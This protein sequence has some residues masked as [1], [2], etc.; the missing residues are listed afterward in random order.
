MSY[1]VLARKYRPQRLDEVIGQEHVSKTL[2]NALAENR[3]AHAYLFAGPRGVGKTTMARI[4]AKA[5]NCKD[6]RDNEP[7]GKCSN[8]VEI[9]N[10][11]SVD[12]QEIDAASN[13]GIDDIRT[14]R[15]NIKFAPATSK[16]K[17]YIID[18]AHQIT[19]EGFNALLKTLEEPPS[20]VVFILATTEAHKMPITIL[21][22]CQRYRFRLLSSKEIM[23]H[24]E[25]I[26]KSENF[27]VESESLQII[28][29]ASGGSVRD[30]LSLLDQA[31]SSVSG[32]VKAQDVQNLL[33]FLPREIIA[34]ITGYLAKEDS[35]GILKTIKNVA[36]Q[37]FNLLQFGRDLRDH[38]RNIL[39]CKASPESL[40]ITADEKKLIESQ[41]NLFTES[42]L[43]RSGHLISRSLDEMRWHDNP[44]I[45]LELYLLKMAQPYL[46]A[47]E[48]FDKIEKLEKNIEPTNCLPAK[49]SEKTS[50]NAAPAEYKTVKSK[51]VE[52]LSDAKEEEKY[53]AAKENFKKPIDLNAESIWNSF[54]NE[55]QNIRPLIWGYLSNAMLKEF[56]ETSVTIGAQNKFEENGIKHNIPFIEEYLKTKLGRPVSVKVVVEAKKTGPENEIPQS[57]EE[58][59][60]EEEN[61][62][63]NTVE[64]FEVKEN[65]SDEK[66]PH[67]LEKILD[68]FPGKIKK[69]TKS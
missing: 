69:K 56:N 16:Y 54:V 18:E 47:K 2:H 36:E 5:L 52:I 3:I 15:E 13:R 28:T 43:I 21:S 19:N 4:L 64:F 11:S 66:I 65:S 37:G 55:T 45:I 24:L 62:G 44:R 61:S 1:V 41:K 59:V 8:C 7:C 33:G 25:K 27:D 67:G 12:V 42:W 57:K 17:V 9:V 34:E 46:N 31:V 49:G 40:E 35:S 51:T 60:V 48:L 6:L 22:R 20:H 26:V 14:L 38:L 50:V 10:G 58:I 30:A 29:S 53:N 32:K 68:K 23:A 63:S 39:L